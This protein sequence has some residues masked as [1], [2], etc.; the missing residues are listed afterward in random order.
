MSAAA[1]IEREWLDLKALTAYASVSERTLRSWI[2]DPVDPLPASQVGTK[3]MVRRST[4][5]EYVE[6]HRV[7]PPASVDRV[8]EEILTG[9]G[10]S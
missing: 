9:M 10:K 1:Q 8:V 4:F 3:I 7:Q 6:R 2:H 5:D